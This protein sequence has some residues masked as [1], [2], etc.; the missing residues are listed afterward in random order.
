MRDSVYI[1]RGPWN[2]IQITS[3]QSP[4]WMSIKLKLN[5][6]E[7]W[8]FLT[9]HDNPPCHREADM[10]MIMN[11]LNTVLLGSPSL[12]IYRYTLISAFRLKS[13]RHEWRLWR[14]LRSESE[15]G[16]EPT[17]PW[18]PEDDKTRSRGRSR[19]L[20]QVSQT[21]PRSALRTE[22]C[23]LR[24]LLVL[25]TSRDYNSIISLHLEIKGYLFSEIISRSTYMWSGCGF[26]LEI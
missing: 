2:F 15:A 21:R 23:V 22:F 10:K 4:I 13:K 5:L 16:L 18:Q 19:S 24:S 9:L 12:F 6:H 14:S 1:E 20:G 3:L 8:L 17:E 25:V 11:T 26:V 7:S